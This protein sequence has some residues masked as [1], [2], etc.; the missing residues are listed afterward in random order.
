MEDKLNF[1]SMTIKIFINF[2]FLILS[3]NFTLAGDV[4]QCGNDSQS[5]GS[6]LR[7]SGNNINVRVGPGTKYKKVINQKSSR[8][9]RKTDYVSIDKTVTVIEECTKS[10]WSKIQV[11][12]PDWLSE[13]HRGWVATKFLK[14]PQKI[15]KYGNWYSDW[16]S[17]FNLDI[18]KTLAA[19]NIRGCGE[20][21]FRENMTDKTD[22]IV[23]C[24]AD[25][26]NWV[27]YRV[28]TSKNK[29]QK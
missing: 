26:K 17:S 3:A 15:K 21:R 16:S 5:S 7:V 6:K 24:N 14:K 11:I 8:I 10:G 20:F 27:Q 9:L 13:S 29:V 2:F 22:F 4:Q 28:S 1:K 23:K 18:A 25:G 12:D 19:N